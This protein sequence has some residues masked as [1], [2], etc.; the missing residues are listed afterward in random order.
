MPFG[1]NLYGT[2]TPTSDKDYKG[3]FVPS[4]QNLYF[5]TC[6]NSLR[7]NTK[8]DPNTKNTKSDVDI[9][10]FSLLFFLKM[11][12]EGNI[13]A[14]DMLHCPKNYLIKTSDVW[15][16]IVKNREKFYT[17]KIV[18]FVDYA[19]GQAAKYGIKGS[20]L[21][22]A[23]KII[24][25]FE[26]FNDQPALKIKDVW[27]GIPKGINIKIYPP[28]G[29]NRFRVVEVCNRKIQETIR[30]KYALEMI[31]KFYSTYG[32]RSIDAEANKNIDWRAVSHAFRAGYQLKQLYTKNTIV[33]PLEEKDFLCQVKKG[34]LIYNEVAPILDSLVDEVEELA[35]QSTLPESVDESFW[36][37]FLVRTYDQYLNIP[38][39]E[40]VM[41]TTLKNGSKNTEVQNNFLQRM[42]AR[43]F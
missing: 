38:I 26:K 12:K 36:D 41:S 28:Q 6:K 15:E 31:K 21:Y 5:Q 13:I 34:E 27:D 33:F 20:R 16:E 23:K 32:Q 40:D 2:A 37:K 35:R 17:K 3:I 1:S 18:N 8:K 11:A 4:K 42:I 29:R 14:M 7:Y 30:V 9:E 10:F 24:E 22:D 43:W 19:R 39:T 25:Y